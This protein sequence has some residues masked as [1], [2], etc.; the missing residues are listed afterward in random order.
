MLAAA[1]GIGAG[2]QEAG[3][4]G[5]TV[6]GAWTL[7]TATVI[8]TRGDHTILRGQVYVN[9]GG[10]P[11]QADG[12]QLATNGLANAS[13]D[14]GFSRWD[15]FPRGA[16]SA[17]TVTNA[18]VAREGA[19]YG[20]VRTDAAGRSFVQDVPVPTAAGAS[21]TFSIWLRSPSEARGSVA[22]TGTGG[23][24][25]RTATGFAVG[26]RW[27]LVSAPLDAS[28]AHSG[29]RAEVVLDTPGV[30]LDV[31]GASLSAGNARDDAQL[32]PLPV[33]PGTGGGGG[34]GGG[35][36]PV[37]LPDGD[38]DGVPDAS[39]LCRT[40]AGTA[41]RRGCPRG[42]TN[43]TS[44]AYKRSGKGIRVVRYYVEAT[45]G[46]RIVVTCSKGCRKTVTQG[47]G[48]KAGAD[49][50]ADQPAPDV[51]RQDHRD[52]LDARPADHEGRR[53][54]AQGPP[55]RRPAPLLHAGHQGR[56]HLLAER[57]NG[58]RRRGGVP[59]GAMLRIV[60]V[61]LAAYA[62]LAAPAQ[63][64]TMT[65]HT[66]GLMVVSVSNTVREDQRSYSAARHGVVHWYRNPDDTAP[67]TSAPA[68]AARRSSR[69]GAA[70]ASRPCV[71]AGGDANDWIDGTCALDCRS[72]RPAAGATT[73]CGGPASTTCSTAVPATTTSSAGPGTTA[74]RPGTGT[75]EV[76]DE[77]GNDT[78][79]YWQGSMQGAPVSVTLDGVANDG[80]PGEN[81]AIDAGIENVNV[82]VDQGGVADRRRQRGAPNELSSAEPLGPDRHDRR[83]RSRRDP[84]GG[85][86]RCHPRPRRVRRHDLV[87]RRRRHR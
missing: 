67:I 6:G 61:V 80:G 5:V 14:Q 7:V 60:F 18:S 31:D 10:V 62:W 26:P 50:A 15:S 47:Q 54:R 43:D 41:S 36:A 53:P 8:P 24:D 59:C 73:R 44:I 76:Q 22:L 81:D 58:L 66:D 17:S 39:D 42:L 21:R 75:D 12:A 71:V 77:A 45:K 38:A 1:W 4:T 2:G 70:S 34:G 86:C 57:P 63:A 52:R 37:P 23:S 33:D 64:A 87:W 79:E 51:G 49:H 68:R 11:L 35:P 20:A 48:R 29:L 56:G 72:G 27:T 83:R 16:L 82:T 28:V 32:G 78:V 13:F 65:V 25:E 84:R 40:Q 55:R 85:G 19:A 9:T 3:T 46:A 74:W 30:E 69:T